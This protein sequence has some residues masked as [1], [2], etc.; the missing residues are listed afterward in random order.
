MV[1]HLG[2]TRWAHLEWGA[3]WPHFLEEVLAGTFGGGGSE[4]IYAV[5]KFG[6]GGFGGHIWVR[7]SR[8]YNSIRRIRYR[9]K[10]YLRIIV[11]EGSGALGGL[12]G[13]HGLSVNVIRLGNWFSALVKPVTCYGA[14]FRM[15]QPVK[16]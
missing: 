12:F 5:G 16:S 9:K 15:G 7:R 4:G 10:T 3:Q 8:A 1:V 2:G 6:G 11:L 14:V 13:T